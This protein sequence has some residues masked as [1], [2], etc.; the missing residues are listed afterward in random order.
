M[1]V[2]QLKR[3]ITFEAEKDYLTFDG[4]SRENAQVAFPPIATHEVA[5]DRRNW[6]TDI[7]QRRT[8]NKTRLFFYLAMFLNSPQE[9]LS[10]LRVVEF[11][12]TKNCYATVQ[13]VVPELLYGTRVMYPSHADT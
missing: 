10:S 9:Q 5:F 8:E 4:L 6:L 2:M 3:D 12:T 1:K 11:L 7:E 13:V